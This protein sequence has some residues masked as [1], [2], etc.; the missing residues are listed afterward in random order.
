[1][2][3][4]LNTQKSSAKGNYQVELTCIEQLVPQDHL[5]R[6]IDEHLDFSFIIDKVRPF[7]SE[8]KGR[9]SLDPILLFKMMLI[10]YLYGIRSERQLEQEIIPHAAYRWFL[11]L[12]F[13][14]PVPDHSTISWNRN[15]RFKG[16]NLFQEIFDEVVHLAINHHM[17]AGR[18]L[19]TDSTHIQANANNNRY[20]MQVIQETPHEYLEELNKAVNDDRI[21][22]GKKP[23]PPEEE[24]TEEKTR[25]VS[26]TDP[27]CGLMK[28]DRKPEGFCYLDH[29]TVD[30]KFNIITDVHVTPGNTNDAAVYIERLQRQIKTF[31]FT[32]TLEAV[33]LDSGYMTPYICH[34]TLSM[35]IFAVIAERSAPTT[36]GIFPKK[37]FTYDPIQ[38]VYVCPAG[39]SLAYV[40]TNRSGYREYQ[41][42]AAR[43]AECPLL[44]QCTA[45]A[46]KQRKIN[47]HVWE[48]S[49]E[50]V[51]HNR[52][53]ET[54]EAVYKLRA[55]TIERSFADAKELHGYRRCKFRG[56]AK[57]QEQALMTAIAQ[58]VKK[59]ARYLAKK[60]RVGGDNISPKSLLTFFG[61]IW[62]GLPQTA[63]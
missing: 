3:I 16:T 8:S 51:A 30:H 33:A 58:N 62:R 48:G 15:N 52:K 41:S 57:A 38:D 42:D 24:A 37:Q 13:S 21:A 32:S 2:V 44:N 11:G 53:S 6:F 63:A 56:K 7:Y 46:S 9:P 27:E 34:K 22:Y 36:P 19:V 4:L 61:I 5:L 39:Q 59:I 31:G 1:V 26:Q 50:Q 12:T 43:C 55:Q 10:G 25:K 35:D 18:L 23:L 60:A 49:K 20:T 29:R 40:T 54:G 14:D 17:V 47:R 28:R 45:T